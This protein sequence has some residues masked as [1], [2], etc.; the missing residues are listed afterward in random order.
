MEFVIYCDESRHVESPDNKYMSIG[1]LWVPRAAK[2]SL[3][4]EFRGL[5]ETL[6]LKGEV[7]WSKV[8]HK[9]LADYQKL[10]DFFFDQ[11][12]LRFRAIVVNQAKVDYSR[13]HQ[14]DREL[15]FYKFY[16]EML[17]KWILPN[18]R[19]LVLLDF[20]K[21]E[22]ADRYTTL[23]RVLER[24]A[25]GSTHIDDLTIIDS[26]ESPLAQLCDL[27]TGSVAATWCKFKT[28]SAKS[29]LAAYIGTRRGTPLQI[30][31]A[32]P[33]LSKFNIFAIELAP[34]PTP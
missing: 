1:G 24:T 3:T 6:R 33:A 31:D 14:G 23:R 26:Y 10:V 19:Y 28:P 9:R 34:G 13:F 4:Q 8:S 27:L 20:K 18:N 25:P 32:S 22:G 5:R 15:G 21:N 17:E 12:D 16:F 2:D 29:L 30:P 11:P 7:K